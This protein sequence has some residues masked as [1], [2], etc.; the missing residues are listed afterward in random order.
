MS[1]EAY[2]CHPILIIPLMYTLRWPYVD[3]L[4]T[5]DQG[6]LPLEARAFVSTLS[7]VPKC[8]FWTPKN[9]TLP[10]P[11]ELIRMQIPGP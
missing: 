11:K 10:S 5:K 9:I 2:L 3:V 1:W 6:Q 8:W 7:I 4:S